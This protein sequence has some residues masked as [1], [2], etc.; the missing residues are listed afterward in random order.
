M[1][2]EFF[3]PLDRHF[4]SG[5]GATADTFHDAAKSLDTEEHKHGFGL[6]RSR[7]PL[8]Y[9]YRHANELYLKSVLT[10]LH[11]RFS[12]TF[13]NVPKGEFPTI[14]DANGKPR[15]IFRVHSIRDLSRQFRTLLNANALHL[16]SVA[17]TDWTAIPT[18]FDLMV[19]LIDAADN[20]STMFRYP[21]TLDPV[22]DANKS[23]FKQVSNE[24]AVA[25]AA[26][27]AENGLPGVMILGLK[28]NNDEIL[29]TFIYDESVMT[30][31]F[32]AHKKLADLLSGLQFGLRVE[33][34]GG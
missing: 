26:Y 14:D 22:N 6:N 4:D 17:R 24:D 1:I 31:V 29:D 15:E 25:A 30:D 33:L 19:N 27:R 23:S 3:M 5:F 8:F 13:P 2:E 32:V 16:L 9:L 28:D 20:K 10:I 18:D 21:L 11:R 12:P 34:L 7:L